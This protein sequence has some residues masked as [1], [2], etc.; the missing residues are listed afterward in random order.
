MKGMLLHNSG[1]YSKDIAQRGSTRCAVKTFDTFP[2]PGY[3]L[4][5]RTLTL[6]KVSL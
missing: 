5:F 3:D 4:Q 2:R 6:T 1:T